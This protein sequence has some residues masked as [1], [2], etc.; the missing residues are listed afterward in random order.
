MV[1][2]DRHGTPYNDRVTART[3]GLGGD[4]VV[5]CVGLGYDYS[6]KGHVV[7]ILRQ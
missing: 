6:L 3:K 7:E 4:P 5:V 1:P 2:F